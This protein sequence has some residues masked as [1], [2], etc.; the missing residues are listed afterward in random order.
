[1]GPVQRQEYLYYTQQIGKHNASFARGFSIQDM[2]VSSAILTPADKEV[3][4]HDG[5][6]HC[7]GECRDSVL[8]DLC[9]MTHEPAGD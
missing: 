4:V 7:E 5:S 1:M 6:I 8:E 9:W 3:I 2:P